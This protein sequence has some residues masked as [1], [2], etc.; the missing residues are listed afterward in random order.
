MVR[1]AARASRAELAGHAPIVLV[2]SRVGGELK[3]NK[4]GG[5]DG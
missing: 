3:T 1:A 4:F 5:G 2:V